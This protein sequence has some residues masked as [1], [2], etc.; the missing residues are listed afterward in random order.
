M[1]NDYQLIVVLSNSIITKLIFE[2]MAEYLELYNTPPFI[3]IL[4]ALEEMPNCRILCQGVLIGCCC[5]G[6]CAE[7]EEGS[8]KP[9]IIVFCRSRIF[10]MRNL[11]QC[12][13][14]VQY[15]IQCIVSCMHYRPF[16]R[17]QYFTYIIMKCPKSIRNK[18]VC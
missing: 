16:R 12:S 15:A 13:V 8:V 6:T 5:Q 9:L 3:H 18:P 10:K 4:T 7:D 1:K 2:V 11:L 17:H 14:T